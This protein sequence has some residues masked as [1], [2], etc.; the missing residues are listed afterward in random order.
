MA[1]IIVLGYI[2]LMVYMAIATVIVTC[3][4]IFGKKP[5]STHS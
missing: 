3:F 2:A 5:E 4:A 1:Q